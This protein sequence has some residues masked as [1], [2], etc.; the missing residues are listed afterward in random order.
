MR[1]PHSTSDLKLIAQRT[2][3]VLAEVRLVKG[4]DLADAFGYSRPN[5]AFHGFCAA[6]GITPVPG[7]RDIYDPRLVRLR[8]DAVQGIGSASGRIDQPDTGP[9][10]VERRKARSANH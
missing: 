8:L 10:L 2:A 4:A 3:D 9:S 7:R 6:I 5:G 1:N